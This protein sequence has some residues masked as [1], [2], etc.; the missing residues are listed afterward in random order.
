M[1]LIQRFFFCLLCL[2]VESSWGD[3]TTM[4]EESVSESAQDEPAIISKEYQGYVQELQEMFEALIVQRKNSFFRKSLRRKKYDIVQENLGDF[5][6][7]V[8]KLGREAGKE[9]IKVKTAYKMLHDKILWIDGFKTGSLKYFSSPSYAHKFFITHD[10]VIGKKAIDH[11][12]K[13]E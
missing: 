5:T 7:S 8:T 12:R 6:Q 11:E 3:E 2:G 10:D 9:D 1:T 13:E 4:P